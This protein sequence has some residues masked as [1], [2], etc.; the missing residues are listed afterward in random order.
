MHEVLEYS[1]DSE[2]LHLRPTLLLKQSSRQFRR[3]LQ[4]AYSI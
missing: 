3:Q 4:Y 2:K 1:T